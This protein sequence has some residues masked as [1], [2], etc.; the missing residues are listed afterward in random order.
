MNAITIKVTVDADVVES[1]IE[2]YKTQTGKTPNKKWIVAFLKE[3]AKYVMNDE[4][5][6]DSLNELVALTV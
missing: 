4:G 2:V 3:Q 6:L 5:T 1:I